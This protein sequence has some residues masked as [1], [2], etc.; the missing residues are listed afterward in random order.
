MRARPGMF[1]G[2]RAR[3]AFAALLVAALL[4]GGAARAETA[5]DTWAALQE[6][7]DRA[8]AGET[9][10][11]SGD[12]S[13]GA[14]DA[15]LNVPTGRNL[16]LDLNGHALD[17]NLHGDED[18]G[19][20]LSIETG[21]IL[22]IR[23]SVGTGTITGGCAGYGGGILNQ[24]AL[25]LEGGCVTG[26]RARGNGGGI[27]NYGAASIVGGAVTGNAASSGGGVYNQAKA[28]LTIGGD[29]VYGNSA[30]AHADIRNDGALT[31]IGAGP[32]GVHIEDI[33]VLRD[34]MTELSVIPT[35]AL[36]IALLLAVWLDAYLTRERKRV[37]VVIIALVFSLVLQNYLDNRLSLRGGA[38][39]V[40]QAVTAYGYA[41]R[42]VI[43]ALFLRIVK[44]DGRYGAAWALIAVNAAVYMTAFFSPIA[45]YYTPDGN[46]RPGPLHHVCTAVSA[47]LLAWLLLLTMRQFR[48]RQ[49]R[50]SWIP[51]LVTALIAGSVAM[52]FNVIFDEQPISFLTIAIAIGC[53]FYYVWLHL[54]FVREHENALRAGQRIQIMMS[55]IQ[56]HFLFNTLS[57][58]Q[59]LCVKDPQT[60]VYAIE[61]FGVYLRKNLESLNQTDLIPLSRELEHTRAYAQIEQLRFRN[62]Q[63]DYDIQ[64]LDVRVPALSIQP[65][66]ENA[67]R[68]G[69]RGRE[70]GRVTVSACR[71]GDENLIVI[72]DNGTG[73]DAS[74]VG[75]E[76][77]G[78]HIGIANVRSRLEQMCG[79]T[80]DIDSRIGEGTTITMHIPIAR[81]A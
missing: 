29:L 19:S 26:N 56:P 68:H 28:N 75:A 46:W 27:A 49:R 51:I 50:E 18:E 13:A 73:F 45:F 1:S 62:I 16:A 14:S 4:F 40:R 61:Q 55:Q 54:Q 67:I 77:G 2:V 7:I 10:V 21:A 24:G 15:T 65:L 3:G 23:D 33:P 81:E 11:L 52:D 39:A 17:R 79:G 20:V 22:T 38:V 35:L 44:P 31:V 63:V 43:L 80:L 32:E 30:A 59:A 41:V 78:R 64:E 53:V 37:M 47:L 69:V 70:K 66:V 72:Q 76:D 42:P 58:I 36:L 57:T 5:V 25:I 71:E 34:Y 6:A 48:P 74:A 12:V 8:E 60:A 9:V